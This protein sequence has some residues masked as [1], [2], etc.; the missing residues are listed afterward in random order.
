MRFDFAAGIDE[1]LCRHA[2]SS[3]PFDQSDYQQQDNGADRGIDDFAYDPGEA[4]A[5]TRQQQAGDESTDNADDDVAKLRNELCNTVD[6]RLR[7]L[8]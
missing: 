4:Q 7:R 2:F 1:C 8:K 5:Q 6:H 3:N